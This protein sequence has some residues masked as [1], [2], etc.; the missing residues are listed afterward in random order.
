MLPSRSKVRAEAL[1]PES[2]SGLLGVGVRGGVALTVVMERG[3]RSWQPF[4]SWGMMEATLNVRTVSLGHKNARRIGP[5][6]LGEGQTPDGYLSNTP[7]EAEL[8]GGKVAG[9]FASSSLFA[10][11][12]TTGDHSLRGFDDDRNGWSHSSGAK[13]LRSRCC[14]FAF[15]RDLSPCRCLSSA[16]ALPW[17]FLSACLHS[18]LLSR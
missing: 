18:R 5:H 12:A 17:P 10:T 4:S 14:R 3:G 7:G 11:A 15:F 13:S 1:R 2:G 8:D 6:V 16:C 9:K